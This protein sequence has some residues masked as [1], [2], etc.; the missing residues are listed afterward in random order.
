RRADFRRAKSLCSG[1][2]LF[3]WQKSPR[4]PN[5]LAKKQW[6]KLP[7]TLTVRIL[8]FAINRRGVRPTR[9]SLVT[10]LLDPKIYPAQ[11]LIQTFLQ[12]WRLELCLDDLK[13]TLGMEQLRTLSP[14]MVERELSAFL[15]AHNLIRCL[16]A[17]AAS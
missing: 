2:G 17:A 11:D 9:I 6:N 10:T 1:D 16:M 3:T 14:A 5:Y 4:R 13:T 8:R 12:R 15:L 7:A